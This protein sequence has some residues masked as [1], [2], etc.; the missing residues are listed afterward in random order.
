M[1]SS[2]DK[3]DS[4]VS[5]AFENDYVRIIESLPEE[6]GGRYYFI[7][8]RKAE[9]VNEH[10]DSLCRGGSALAVSES[11]KICLVQQFRASFDQYVWEIPRGGAE[12]G[13]KG[14]E[15]GVREFLEETGVPE[16]LI[17]SVASMGVVASDT[18]IFHNLSEMVFIEVSDEALRYCGNGTGDGEVADVQWFDLDEILE[19]FEKNDGIVDAFTQLAIYKAMAKGLL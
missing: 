8:N 11:G 13:D 19:S 14:S 15:T 18:G 10:S 17:K 3:S 12:I 7:G 2:S 6:V 5:V 4:P 9:S 16:H 1:I